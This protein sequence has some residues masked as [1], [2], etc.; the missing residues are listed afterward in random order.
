MTPDI[1]D[2]ERRSLDRRQ[3]DRLGQISNEQI[4][5]AVARLEGRSDAA[6]QEMARGM[7]DLHRRIEDKFGAI[8]EHLRLQDGRLD[9]I[10]SKVSIA[11]DNALIARQGATRAGAFS[12][13]GVTAVL[14]GG[15][16]I[17]KA[18]LRG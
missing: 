1:P 14:Q 3:E 9:K 12:A 5:I 10:E 15:I 17:A 16:E 4:Y 18:F 8:Q 7:Q 11:H 13:A 6:A 2:P